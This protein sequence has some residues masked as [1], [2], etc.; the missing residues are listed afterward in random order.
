VGLGGR[1]K[2]NA[3]I[4][5]LEE[6]GILGALVMCLPVVMCVF[7][8]FRIKRLNAYLVD[9]PG[10]LRN[11]ARLAAAFWAGA[12]GGLVNNLAEATLWSAGSPYGGML[13]FLAG[14][15]EG[16]VARTEHRL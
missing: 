3:F 7:G 12:M 4:A 2:G 6:T 10:E 5:I 16:L 11:D 8:G 15:S 1:E 9:N 14:A 13:L